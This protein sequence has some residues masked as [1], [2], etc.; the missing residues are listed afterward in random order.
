[1]LDNAGSNPAL[2]L[3]EKLYQSKDKLI[4]LLKSGDLAE[5]KKILQGV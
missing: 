1:M 4:E 3:E 5:A 2:S